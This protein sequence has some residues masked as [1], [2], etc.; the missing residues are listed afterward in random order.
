MKI[1]KLI[2]SLKNGRVL[3]KCLL[4]FFLELLFTMGSCASIDENKVCKA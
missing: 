1:Y 2:N 3:I 4:F